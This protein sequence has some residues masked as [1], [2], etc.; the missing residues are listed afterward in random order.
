M[1]EFKINYLHLLHYFNTL[2]WLLNVENIIHC[3]ECKMYPNLEVLSLFTKKTSVGNLSDG[4]DNYFR[5]RRNFNHLTFNPE[6][7]RIRQLCFM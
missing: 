6:Q 4:L 7:C 3:I 1:L 2:R 5:H